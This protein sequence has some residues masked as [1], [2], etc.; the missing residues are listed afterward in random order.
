MT[1]KGILFDKDGTLFD[2]QKT[3]GAWTQKHLL[4]LVEG[5]EGFAHQLGMSIGYDFLRQEF[6]PGSLVVGGT[7][8]DIADVL[9]PQMAG[10]SRG[11]LIHR[12]NET[13]A[14]VNVVEASPLAPMLGALR[15]RGIKLGV[16]TND[17][18][19]GAMANLAQVGIEHSFDYIAGFDSGYGCKPEP[20]MLLGFANACGFEPV[21]GVMVGDS[22]HDL[23]AGRAAG[24][25]VVAVLTG[26]A[27]ESD[28]SPHADVVLP[29]VGHLP[30]WL[31]SFG[32]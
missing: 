9:V 4:E 10:W 27:S 17:S 24:M 3:W 11:D 20:G 21:Q 13:T 19:A 28:L 14:T 26:V 16:A 7:V 8:E 1:F 32:G 12:L 2:F 31:D 25:T 15:A 30:E 5:D 23:A 6:A 18:E 29:D 22:L